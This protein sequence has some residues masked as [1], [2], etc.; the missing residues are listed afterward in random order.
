MKIEENLI[1]SSKRE[2]QLKKNESNNLISIT[3]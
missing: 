1:V 2:E 3:N